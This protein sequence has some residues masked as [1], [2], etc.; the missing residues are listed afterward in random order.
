MQLGP[1][2]LIFGAIE[3]IGSKLVSL[4]DLKTFPASNLVLCIGPSLGADTSPDKIYSNKINIFSLISEVI[5][6]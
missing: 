5:S 6:W 4:D 2:V 3:V 1:I